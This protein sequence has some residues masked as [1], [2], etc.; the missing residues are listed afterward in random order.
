MLL[1]SS[2]QYYNSWEA[3]GAFV[4][5]P[6]QLV[7][8]ALT[9]WRIVNAQGKTHVC[10]YMAG[11]IFKKDQPPAA[12]LGNIEPVAHHSTDES[13]A[14]IRNHMDNVVIY[15]INFKIA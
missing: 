5:S 13:S 10:E 6:P 14:S 11:G 15:P 8:L 1:D 4:Y 12:E 7:F 3:K 9:S 2:I